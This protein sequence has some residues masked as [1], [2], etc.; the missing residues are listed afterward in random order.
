MHYF[1]TLMRL[2]LLFVLPA[3]GQDIGGASFATGDDRAMY[4]QK[5]PNATRSVTFKPFESLE[6]NSLTPSLQNIEWTWNVN[7]SDYAA[8]NNT[9]T[10]AHNLS[11]PYITTTSYDFPDDLS[12]HVLDVLNG[13]RLSLCFSIL[14]TYVDLPVS[15]TNAYNEGNKDQTSCVPALGQSCVDAILSAGR[16]QESYGMCQQ[17]LELVD[18]LPECSDVLRLSDRNNTRLRLSGQDFAAGVD[19]IGDHNGWYGGFDNPKN[20]SGGAQYY[21]ALNRVHMVLFSPQLEKNPV[22]YY[23]GPQLLCM[24]VNTT[25]LPVRD[26]NGDGASLTSESVAQGNMESSGSVVAGCDFMA[27]V[28][29]TTLVLF[30]V[31]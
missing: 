31:V 9:V 2:W 21:N 14:K 15:F 12:Q 5:N 17:S 10:V 25:Q 24:R 1:S 3:Y 19:H 11:D 6:N 30:F 22:E 8:E 7:I 29:F 13:T 16:T 18:G 20:G 28:T 23:Q 4:A 26:L 27:I